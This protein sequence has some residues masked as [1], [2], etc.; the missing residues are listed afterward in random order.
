MTETVFLELFSLAS[1]LPGPT[2][3]QV[4][5]A[6]GTIKRGV[7]SGLLGGALFQYPGALLMT[8]FGIGAARVLKSEQWWTHAIVDGTLLHPDHAAAVEHICVR[9]FAA[10]A[11]YIHTNHV[12]RYTLSSG[13]LLSGAST[14]VFVCAHGSTPWI[15]L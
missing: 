10:H 2:A 4:S 6:I 3:T 9:R 14:R 5:C 15:A 8:V 12:R 11:Q 7:P 1:C 13:A